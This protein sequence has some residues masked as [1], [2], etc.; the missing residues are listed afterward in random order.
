M[1]SVALSGI[2]LGLAWFAAVNAVVS[3][4]VWAAT[5]A[6]WRSAS[7]A[8]PG[9]FAGLRLLPAGASLL[10]TTAVFLPAHWRFEPRDAGES[11]GLIV[12][13]LAAAAAGLLLRSAWRG[14]DVLRADRRL[15]AWMSRLSPLAGACAV[16]MYEVRGWGGVSL[17]GVLRTRILVGDAARAVLSRA[18]LDVAV[19]HEVAHRRA[20]DNVKRFAMACAPD[21]LNRRTAEHLEA[22]WRSAAE[23]D[24]DARAVDGDR[25]RALDL[26]SA[27]VKIARTH[28][29][30]PHAPAW[31]A[32]HEAALLETRVRQLVTDGPAPCSE[33][34]PMFA[35]TLVALSA[36]VGLAAAASHPLHQ[37][38]E[39]L[40]RSLP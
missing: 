23:A 29:S 12:F 4:A 6:A 13:A 37:L 24:A 20:G 1:T 14:W 40:V 38:T 25:G 7:R 8:R 31:S 28:G 33:P 17:A 34:R 3:L 19:A 22:R 27:L 5:H 21:L 36:L 9:V 10:F 11:F 30:G 15:R 26:A 39:S 16:E 2:L 18:E 32:L 35:W